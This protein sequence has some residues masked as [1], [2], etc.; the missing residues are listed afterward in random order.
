MTHYGIICPA[1]TGHLNPMTTLGRE[2][3][4]RGH[5]VTVVGFLDAQPNAIA[6]GLDF[7]A[8]AESEY[9]EGK[10]ARVFTQLAKLS[11]LAALRY[12]ISVFQ[13]ITTLLLQNTP[14]A[15]AESGIEALLVD[16]ATSAGGTV[17]EYLDIPLVTVCSALVLN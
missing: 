4:R 9:P 5:R 1:L 2:L 7:L 8:L 10:T 12:T 16:Q 17:A 6:A 15:I 14:R 13:E 3:Q 11:G